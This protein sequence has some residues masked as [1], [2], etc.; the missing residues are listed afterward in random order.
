M[1]GGGV[2]ALTIEYPLGKCRAEMLLVEMLQTGR[3]W[4]DYMEIIE[5]L[6]NLRRH[7]KSM[8]DERK[9]SQ[10]NQKVE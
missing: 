8:E 6:S 2:G 4:F 3:S 1:S 10:E 7:I 9:E 5:A